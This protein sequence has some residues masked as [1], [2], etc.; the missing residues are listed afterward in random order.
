MKPF[1]DSLEPDFQR[2]SGKACLSAANCF[3][4]ACIGSGFK[5][6]EMDRIRL[7]NVDDDI[8]ET[9]VILIA[10]YP[11]KAEKTVFC[12]AVLEQTGFRR[13]RC[14]RRPCRCWPF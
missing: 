1:I 9:T 14:E 2:A 8:A 13:R 5:S 10:S 11:D 4:D 3:H 7:I 6:I 12:A